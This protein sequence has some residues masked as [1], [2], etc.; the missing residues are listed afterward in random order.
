MALMMC[1]ICLRPDPMVRLSL[2]EGTIA[3]RPAAEVLA[4]V[5]DVPVLAGDPFPQVC[6]SDCWQQLE[7][8]FNL[9]E[10]VRESSRKLGEMLAGLG[11]DRVVVKQELEDVEEQQQDPIGTGT[12][13]STIV[14]NYEITKVEMPNPEYK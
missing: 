1:R 10:L 14:D 5:A 3:G 12:T 4:I 7:A 6:C 13:W 2:F 11:A 8:A 9:R